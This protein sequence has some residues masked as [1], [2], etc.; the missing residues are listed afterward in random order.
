[1]WVYQLNYATS[2]DKTVKEITS[3]RFI[4]CIHFV[5]DKDGP[6]FKW[7]ACIHFRPEKDMGNGAWD[8]RFIVYSAEANI[9][10]GK[11]RCNFWTE[12]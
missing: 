6:R 1:M 9:N 8:G 7:A 12:K 11:I 2:T 10:D 5:R 4:K 3:Y